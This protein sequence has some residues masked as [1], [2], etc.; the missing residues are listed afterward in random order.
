MSP[1]IKRTVT[2]DD[3]TEM[4]LL[5]MGTWHHGPKNEIQDAL[6]FA[7]RNG[8]RHIDGAHI[9]LNE[10]EVGEVYDELIRHGEVRRRDLYI[11]SKVSAGRFRCTSLFW[12]ILRR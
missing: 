11:A 12:L 4:P 8:Y 1:D 10:A 2:L 6:R 5:G 7:I 9:Y 3:G